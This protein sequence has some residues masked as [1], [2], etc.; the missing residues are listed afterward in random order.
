MEVL[1]EL[2]G[3]T[4]VFCGHE[5]TAANAEFAA[6]VEP[7]NEAIQKLVRRAVSIPAAGSMCF[8]AY[9]AAAVLVMLPLCCAADQ[10]DGCCTWQAPTHCAVHYR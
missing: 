5:Y 8:T 4:F 2:F 7:E 10:G 9:T 3:D 1:P 6:W